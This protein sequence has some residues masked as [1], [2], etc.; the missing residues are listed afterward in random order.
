M[1]CSCFKAGFK[2]HYC[3]GVFF[4]KKAKIM[5]DLTDFKDQLVNSKLAF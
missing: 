3:G 2:S 1:N 5:Q 4:V